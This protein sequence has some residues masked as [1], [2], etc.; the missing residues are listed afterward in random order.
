MD[1]PTLVFDAARPRCRP[2]RRTRSGSAPG[3]TPAARDGC[4]AAGPAAFRGPPDARCGPAGRR[5]HPPLDGARRPGTVRLT[6]ALGA[7]LRPTAHERGPRRQ[8]APGHGVGRPVRLPSDDVH[9]PRAGPVVTTLDAAGARSLRPPGRRRPSGRPRLPHRGDWRGQ[10]PF[11]QGLRGGPR[12][13]RDHPVSPSYI[14]MAEYRGRLPLFHL[15][16]YRLLDAA[17]AL[18]GGLRSMT[19]SRV[20]SR[21]SSGRSCS[22]M[23]CPRRP[24]RRAHR[25][26]GRRAA[27]DHAPTAGTDGSIAAFPGGGGMTH[28]GRRRAVL[29]IDTA[30][31][32]VVIGD[33]LARWLSLRRHLHLGS[34]LP[35]WRDV[36]A[37]TIGRFLGEQNIPSSLVLVGIVVGTGPA[38][39]HRSA[40]RHRDRQ[41]PRARPG[42]PPRGRVDR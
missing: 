37:P 17:D 9:A 2:S 29:A 30:T 35:P 6:T 18:A 7:V 27:D 11:R 13:D 41:G 39:L 10:D 38:P 4:R 42:H 5:E 24:P 15:E 19:A 8:V 21:S 20:G 32:R 40:R 12:G 31:T 25:G 14:L 33:R 1:P 26:V 28:D 23:P 36:A 34:R 22:A 16:L 3:C